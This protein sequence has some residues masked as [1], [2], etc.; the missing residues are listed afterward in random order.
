MKKINVL[1]KKALEMKV[2]DANNTF[3][4]EQGKCE[5]VWV[6]GCL[7]PEGTVKWTKATC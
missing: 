6:N 5:G 3:P 7:S 2:E 4:C 1:N